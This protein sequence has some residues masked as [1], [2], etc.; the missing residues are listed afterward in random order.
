MVVSILIM[1][2]LFWF[3]V[4]LLNLGYGEPKGT[5]FIAAAV[6]LLTI[7]GGFVDSVFAVHTAGDLLAGGLLFSHGLLY[8][9]IA[10][11]LLYGVENMKT[12]GNI[13]LCVAFVSTIYMVVWW[14]QGNHYLAFMAAGYAVLTYEVWLNFYGKLSGKVVALSLLLWIPIGLWIPAF[15]IGM[16]KPLPF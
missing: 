1:I 9:S 7:A 11:A 13:S 2:S 4:A 12:I 10:Y 14:I 16:S 8:M 3:A 15:L 5:G 6:G